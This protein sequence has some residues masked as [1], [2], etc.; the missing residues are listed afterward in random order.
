[1][2]ALVIDYKVKQRKLQIYNP[3]I[4]GK[5]QIVVQDSHSQ[6]AMVNHRK[7]I[8]PQSEYMEGGY[9]LTSVQYVL[10]EKYIF[11]NIYIYNPMKETVSSTGKRC[12]SFKFTK[13]SFSS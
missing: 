2:A 10:F 13:K 11:F 3:S 5:Q 8:N 12:W 4:S 6:T 7:S 1:M 9:Q